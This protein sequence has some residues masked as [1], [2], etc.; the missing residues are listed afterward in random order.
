MGPIRDPRK[1]SRKLTESDAMIIILR[2]QN[3]ELQHRIAGD[4][5][6]NAGRISEINTGKRFPH[7]RRR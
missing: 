5:D 4:F 6:V 7:L 2:L 1:P 3:G